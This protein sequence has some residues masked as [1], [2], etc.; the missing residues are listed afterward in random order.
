MPERQRPPHPPEGTGSQGTCEPWLRLLYP[1]R[2]GPVAQRR[3]G[4]FCK[5]PRFRVRIPAGSPKSERETIPWAF[6]E[7]RSYST[8]GDLIA[9]AALGQVEGAV[10]AL[11]RLSGVSSG[12]PAS[13]G[14]IT[15]TLSTR[16]S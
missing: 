14:E 10:G 13:P 15:W 16:A 2:P 8:I 7:G 5:I 6:R 9:A 12:R 3:A 4:K 11:E 1:S